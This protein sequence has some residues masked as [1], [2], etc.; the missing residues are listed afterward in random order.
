MEEINPKLIEYIETHI[1]PNYKK[2]EKAHQIEHIQY[3]IK[4]SL[5]LCEDLK[6]NKEIAYTIAAYHD[7]GHYID[8]RNHEVVSAKIFYEDE[9]MKK[10]F[11]EEERIIIKE[12]I[13][14]HRSSHHLEPR[15]VYGKVVSS[16][17][18]N[19]DISVAIKRAYWYGIKYHPGYTFLEQID[20]VYQYIYHRFYQNGEE[21][22]YYKDE[23]YLKYVQ[24]MSDLLNDKT[25]FIEFAK[26]ID[27]T[28]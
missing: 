5:K 28:K 20:R 1:F 19:I 23:A 6:L 21:T 4:R 26:K 10:Y 11:T 14:D 15:S 9:W 13:E 12:A 25:A 2:N 18:R 17:D 7:C 16:A 3:V 8:A 27:Y 22:M 24:E